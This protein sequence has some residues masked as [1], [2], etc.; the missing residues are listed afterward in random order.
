M[1]PFMPNEMPSLMSKYE[2]AFPHLSLALY[3]V[4]YVHLLCDYRYDE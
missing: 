2:F 3:L 4:Q 1:N